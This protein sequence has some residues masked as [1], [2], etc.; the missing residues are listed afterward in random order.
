[1]IQAVMLV[2]GN[3]VTGW[4][5]GFAVEKRL[6]F[7]KIVFDIFRRYPLQIGEVM[8]KKACVAMWTI[9]KIMQNGKVMRVCPIEVRQTL[10]WS[11]GFWLFVD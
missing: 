8:P 5:L 11:Q 1:M 9:V 10:Q 2:A 3:K 6:R 7:G 4:C